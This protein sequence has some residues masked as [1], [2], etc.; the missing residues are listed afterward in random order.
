MS[1]LNVGQRAVAVIGAGECGPETAAMAENLGRLLAL[2][3]FSVVCGGLGGV[4]EAACRG[5]LSAGGLTIGI[6]PGL[7]RA[8]ANPFV[9]VPVVTGLGPMRNFLVVSN[10][11]AAV[12]VEGGSGTLSEIALAQKSGIPVI[13]L[14]RW[15]DL[16]GVHP[17][18]DPEQAVELVRRFA[19]DTD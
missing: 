19:A 16:P 12:A 15:S 8:A 14:G 13:A 1:Q 10:G 4:M 5:A 18:R 9:A 2:A 6:L 7:E 17:A 11:L 3:G